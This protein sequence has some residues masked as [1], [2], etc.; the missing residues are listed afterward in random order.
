MRPEIRVLV[1]L[2]RLPSEDDAEVEL[3]ERYETGLLQIEP[4]V[5]DE[6]AI[7]LVGLYGDDG[8]FGL[9]S[10]LIHLIET[11]PGWPINEVLAATGNPWILELKNRAIRAGLL[12]E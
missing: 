8:C 6:E 1:E 3:L 7:A 10:T 4:P 9:A 5:T 11:A 2:G 12:Q